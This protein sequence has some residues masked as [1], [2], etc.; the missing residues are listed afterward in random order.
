VSWSVEDS[1]QLY[2]I[3]KWG[4]PFFGL[5][6][7][8]H[9]AISE[10]FEKSS[11]KQID[12]LELVEDLEKRGIKLPLLV[13]F[14][15]VLKERVRHLF[16]CF[17]Q[18]IA[19]S[20]YQGKYMGVYP[21]KVNQEKHLV[22]DLMR[23]GD[24]HGLGLEC[25]SK[26][27]LLIA[28]SKMK[29]TEGL[30]ICNGFKDFDYIET[31]LLSL[32]MGRNTIIVIDR[33]SELSLV[34]KAYKEHGIRPKIGFR[35]KLYSQGSGRW[36]ESSGQ[37][38]KFGLSPSEIVEACRVLSDEGLL[39]CLEL[40]HYHIGSQVPS[41]QDIKTSLKEGGRFFSELFELGAKPKYLDV[42]G[43][44]GVNYDGSGNSQS[45]VN[46]TDQEYANDVIY[47][48]KAICQERSIPHPN[49]ITE[50]GRALVAH[51]SVLI[52]NV[53]GSNQ[54]QKL[55]ETKE[56]G[57]TNHQVLRDLDDVAKYLNKRTII[58]SYNDLNQ[59]R[60]DVLQLFSYGVLNLSQRA[61]AEVMINNLYI[62]I[63]KIAKDSDMDFTD[64][65]HELDSLLCET[66]YCNFSL[67]Q[68]L[69]DSWAMGQVFPVI[70]LHRHNEE[71][72]K[73]AVLVDLTCDSDGTLNKFIDP[74]S[75]TPQSYLEVHDVHEDEPY[76][77]GVF[78]TGAYQEI[79]GD[80]HNLFGDTDAVHVIFDK[81][82]GYKVVDV[83]EGDTIGEMLN[84]VSFE[85]KNLI[86]D[87]KQDCLEA[88]NSKMMTDRE[89]RLLIKKF[90]ESLLSYTYLKS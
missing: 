28:L 55:R 85:P 34:L 79:L 38:S 32:K 56:I 50:S 52:F 65:I 74:T 67:F 18:A 33:F 15:D 17:N 24:Q 82:D 87:L 44:L 3:E 84:Y 51:S 30:L 37:K 45:S 75:S 76:Y 68:S 4:Y 25:G 26:P 9:V 11:S 90:E 43:G 81:D 71:P 14:P 48:I 78:L 57:E 88:C 39:D 6:K 72:T 41:I 27:E 13:R 46:Y 59:I 73:R 5:N 42:G 40:L 31:A 49:I 70:P 69:P 8:G 22:E 66:Y 2:G 89:S 61:T 12:L 86:R 35:A 20:S 36:A 83:V 47:T 54:T 77:I 21:V 62:K 64:L 1:R 16:G 53:L 63:K 7:K 58:E 80:M 23:L 10:N 60:K 19:E 29:S